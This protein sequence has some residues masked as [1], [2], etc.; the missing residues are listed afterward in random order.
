MFPVPV[1]KVYATKVCTSNQSHIQ[2]VSFKYFTSGIVWISLL[3]IYSH[4]SKNIDSELKMAFLSLGFNRI[5]K[6]SIDYH[7]G[8]GT[9]FDS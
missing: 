5:S 1:A 2:L 7:E 3:G 9:W 8:E 6:P 4:I